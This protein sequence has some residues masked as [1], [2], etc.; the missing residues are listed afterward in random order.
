MY[1]RTRIEVLLIAVCVVSR[2][3]WSPI[4]SS[5]AN[6]IRIVLGEERCTVQTVLLLSSHVRLFLS[7]FEVYHYFDCGF[8]FALTTR[9]TVCSLAARKHFCTFSFS[10]QE[11]TGKLQ[12]SVID[13][14]QCHIDPFD[15]DVFMPYILSALERQLQRST[16]S[17]SP[18]CLYRSSPACVCVCVC[19]VHCAGEIDYLSL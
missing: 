18:T 8:C 13:L 11:E 4:T 10:A 3:V 6:I 7:L 17:G 16:V 15:L 2:C 14:L 5:Q 1:V 19:V 9:L 12:Q